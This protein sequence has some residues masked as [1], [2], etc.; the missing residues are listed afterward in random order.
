MDMSMLS[1]EGGEPFQ[2]KL[3]SDEP[4]ELEN[5]PLPP[6]PTV[7]P[8][9]STPI[10]QS[11]PVFTSGSLPIPSQPQFSHVSIVKR[12]VFFKAALLGY[13]LQTT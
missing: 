10:S 3:Q 12:V 6:E 2:K 4:V 1:E 5:H 11:T 13:N 9:A 7:S 8:Q